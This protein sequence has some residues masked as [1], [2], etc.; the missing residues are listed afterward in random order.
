MYLEGSKIINSRYEIIKLICEGGMSCIYLAKDVNL[1]DRLVVLKL[2]KREFVTN[3]HLLQKEAMTLTELKHP[4]L[5][6]IYDYF[7]LNNIDEV[8]V[9]E[10]IEG[11]MLSTI[12]KQLND[13]QKY[14][15]IVQ[16][17]SALDYLHNRPIPIVHR[18]IKPNNIMVDLQLNVKVIDFGISAT[19]KKEEDVNGKPQ[20]LFGTPL[21]IA[22]ELLDGEKVSYKA[23]LYSLAILILYLWQKDHAYM[24]EKNKNSEYFV[25][26]H[27]KQMPPTF[28]ELLQ[29]M[30]QNDPVNRTL[31][32]YEVKQA[33]KLLIQDIDKEVIH[34]QNIT[35]SLAKKIV[36]MNLDKGAGATSIAIALTQLFSEKNKTVTYIEHAMM[37]SN[38]H[39]S[40]LRA[41]KFEH[42]NASSYSY[43]NAS[44]TSFYFNHDYLSLQDEDLM[45]LLNLIDVQLCD[46]IIIDLSS[47][48]SRFK[49][50]TELH[51]I[52]LL[53]VVSSPDVYIMNERRLINAIKYIQANDANVIHIANKQLIDEQQSILSS[54]MNV[55]DYVQMTHQSDL[56]LLDEKIKGKWLH[57]T[58]KV[59]LYIKKRLNSLNFSY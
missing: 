2:L 19:F 53:I 6:I 11:N 16:I 4:N 31:S 5:P 9:M 46:L 36:V 3:K 20:P 54:Y 28:K 48:E 24:K 52:D 51:P 59:M 23:D 32:L 12:S 37:D 47:N 45:E 57:P 18:D 33:F 40:Y 7:T 44:N 15:L 17:A 50:I 27:F 21:Y 41:K 56:L 38:A 39:M 49:L 1:N 14:K 29:N 26:K 42:D 55:K 58:S 25:L 30:L 34:K 35:K 10:Y 13:V 8:I 22:P 43:V